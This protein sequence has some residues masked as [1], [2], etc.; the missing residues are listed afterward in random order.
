[1]NEEFTFDGE[2]VP[3]TAARK[4]KEWNERTSNIDKNGFPDTI[5]IGEHK[6]RTTILLKNMHTVFI[7]EMLL[8]KLTMTAEAV[9]DQLCEE[10]KDIKNLL[11]ESVAHHMKKKCRPHLQASM[12]R[13]YGWSEAG[14]PCKINVETKGPNVS[15]LGTIDKSDLITH[16]P[17]KKLL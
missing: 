6:G 9:I 8:N 15:I 17:E 3:S 12:H 13:Y 1:M 11:P 2:T 16:S 4:L 7:F 14:K 5:T 10:F